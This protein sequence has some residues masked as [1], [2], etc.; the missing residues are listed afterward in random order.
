M[1]KAHHTLIAG[2]ADTMLRALPVE[3]S[4]LRSRRVFAGS[5][6]NLV[7]ISL[8]EGQVMKEHTT[9]SPVLIQVLGGHAALDVD[10]ERVDLPTGS[11]VH[12]DADLA[13]SVEAL[14]P[15]H[16]LLTLLERPTPA[17]V[18]A[19][20]LR[21]PEKTPLRREPAPTGPRPSSVVLSS[22]GGDALAVELVTTRHAELSGSLAA[23]TAGLLDAAAGANGTRVAAA[24]TAL[25][26]WSLTTLTALLDSEQLV[27]DPAVRLVD[28]ALADRLRL[29]RTGIAA[30]VAQLA[31]RSAAL[32]IATAAVALRVQ[33]SHHL[34]TF[35]DHALPALAGASE[36]R[37]DELWGEI[38]SSVG[39]GARDAHPHEAHATD[40][41]HSAT[42]ECGVVDEPDFPEL[43]VRTVPHA[44]RHAT[45]FGALDAIGDGKGLVLLAP[46]DPLPL[47][48]QIEERAPGRFTVDYL[49][50][51]PETWRLMLSAA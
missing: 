25:V 48:A 9:T 27:L 1:T 44:I 47:L 43:D 29:E 32:E 8:D 17:V 23:L 26:D 16:L 18:F 34:R 30:A 21:A 12:L 7:R 51:G 28:A 45:V 4:S 35:A 19:R 40:P 33:I 14:T 31:E 6:A 41:D 2:D 11:I 3:A 46:H 36:L 38:E 50:R 10:G 5:G 22:S 39:G 15:A 13:H 49:D 20:K 37:L 42:C 24:H